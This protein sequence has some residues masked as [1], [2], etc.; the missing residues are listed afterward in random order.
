MLVSRELGMLPSSSFCLVFLSYC[1]TSSHG[2][3]VM[4]GGILCIAWPTFFG[5]PMNI[6]SRYSG[7][8]EGE[9]LGR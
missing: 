6:M 1:C 3:Y 5:N 8:E 9:I 2:K 7:T 4:R